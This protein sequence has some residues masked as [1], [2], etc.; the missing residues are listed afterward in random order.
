MPDG[1]A[2]GQALSRV[3]P[4]ATKAAD[5]LTCWV[6]CRGEPDIHVCGVLRRPL[7]VNVKEATEGVDRP[8]VRHVHDELLLHGCLGATGEFGYIG[9]LD[10]LLWRD[11]TEGVKTVNIFTLTKYR[12]VLFPPAYKDIAFSLHTHPPIIHTKESPPPHSPDTQ[13]TSRVL[14][15]PSP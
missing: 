1:S 11:S 9:R 4:Q 15:R 5:K 13:M 6:W 3:G 7:E 10:Y 2:P 12:T 14:S 8:P